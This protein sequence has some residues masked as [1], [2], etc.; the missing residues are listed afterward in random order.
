MGG[1]SI[2]ATLDDINNLEPETVHPASNRLL[3]AVKFLDE[4]DDGLYISADESKNPQLEDLAYGVIIKTGP[5]CKLGYKVGDIVGYQPYAGENIRP[6]LSTDKP[7]LRVLI[8][9]DVLL[10]I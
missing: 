5:S 1:Y 2:M 10:T 8:E 9:E 4:T 6:A 3:L 7:A